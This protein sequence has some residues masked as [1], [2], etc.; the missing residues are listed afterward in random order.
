MSKLLEELKQFT[1]SDTFYRHPLYRKYVFTEGVK[2]LAEEAGAFWI[3]DYIFSNQ[4]EKAIQGQNF[5]VW[6]LD[7]QDDESAVFRVEDGNSNLVKQ[8]TIPYTDF[9]LKTFTL[10]FIGETLL[11]PS[12]Y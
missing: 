7:V 9:P 2:Y 3:I 12:E 4:M 11:L 6:E 10:W 1:G 8:F 5:Q